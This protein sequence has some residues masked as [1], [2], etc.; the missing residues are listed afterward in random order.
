[1][2]TFATPAD[3]CSETEPQGW[4]DGSWFF[5]KAVRFL[6]IAH[7]RSEVLAGI[8]MS[9]G[10]KT[11][12]IVSWPIFKELDALTSHGSNARWHMVSLLTLKLY[13]LLR[14]ELVLLMQF[15]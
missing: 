7:Y 5:P 8:V 9:V 12:S 1:L 14:I 13:P 10:S 11:D 6:D 4:N 15:L 3:S 2:S